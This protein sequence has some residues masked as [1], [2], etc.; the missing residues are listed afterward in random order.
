[1]LLPYS[2]Q[3]QIKPISAN[4]ESKYA[5]IATEVENNDLLELLTPK[6]LYYIQENQTDPNVI[7][8][9]TGDV[10]VDCSGDTIKHLGLNYVIAYL[11]YSKYVLTSPITDT[12]TGFVQKVR[13]EAENINPKQQIELINNCKSIALIQFDII[14]KYLDVKKD[15]FTK[16]CPTKSVERITP[17]FIPI[18]KT[19]YGK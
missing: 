13:Q 18:S 15:I 8:L 3:Q 9:M 14:K 10:F 19:N 17:K 6:F 16:W 7:K 5:Q 2:K 4:N 1:M 12:Y 11:N